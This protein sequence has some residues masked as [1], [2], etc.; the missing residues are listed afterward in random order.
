MATDRDASLAAEVAQAISELEQS[1]QEVTRSAV[2]KLTGWKHQM[3]CN[4]KYPQTQQLMRDVVARR[5]E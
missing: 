3:L 4:A 2:C 1:G 5:Q